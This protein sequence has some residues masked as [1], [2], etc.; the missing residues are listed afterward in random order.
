MFIVTEKLLDARDRRSRRFARRM[1]SEEREG[2]RE[3]ESRQNIGLHDGTLR[4]FFLFKVAVVLAVLLSYARSRAAIARCRP[5]HVKIPPHFRDARDK[6]TSSSEE[7]REL[8]TGADGACQRALTRSRGDFIHS[9]QRRFNNSR[10]NLAMHSTSPSCS[11]TSAT[12]ECT[13]HCRRKRE[14]RFIT[15]FGTART[16]LLRGA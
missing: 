10:Q 1:S 2:V 9:Q 13:P 11:A 7:K 3:R 8:Y 15:E 6:K 5:R 12:F 4:V 16:C 14:G